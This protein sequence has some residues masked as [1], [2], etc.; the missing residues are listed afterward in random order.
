MQLSR[1]AKQATRIDLSIPRPPITTTV[2][3]FF[4]SRYGISQTVAPHRAWR[5]TGRATQF[6]KLRD[7][8]IR[9]AKLQLSRLERNRWRFRVARLQPR[10]LGTT[11]IQPMSC[12]GAAAE[13]RSCRIGVMKSLICERAGKK[14]RDKVPSKLPA[15][16][17]ALLV[18]VV[19]LRVSRR[20][21]LRRV[22]RGEDIGNI[23]PFRRRSNFCR[24]KLA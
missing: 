7:R 20:I 22:G 11:Q 23:V 4:Q 10:P 9:Q 17:N 24:T 2:N 19:F 6:L 12:P 14:Q 5:A 1:P 15:F 8:A 21:T 16:L 13:G 3:D 18:F